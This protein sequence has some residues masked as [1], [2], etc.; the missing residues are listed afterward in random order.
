MCQAVKNDAVCNCKSGRYSKTFFINW[1]GNDTKCDGIRPLPIS[2]QIF[3]LIP[4]MR[5]WVYADSFDD[6]YL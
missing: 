4:L 5:T 6:S 1:W 2:L 3:L